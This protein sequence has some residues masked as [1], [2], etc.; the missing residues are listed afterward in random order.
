MMLRDRRRMRPEDAAI[1]W[2]LDNFDAVERRTRPRR[3]ARVPYP[4]HNCG[5]GYKGRI[6]RVK[7]ERFC[8]M[9]GKQIRKRR[10]G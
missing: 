4:R 6:I 7:G 3:N 8:E 1:R 9:C 10:T 5:N 2:L